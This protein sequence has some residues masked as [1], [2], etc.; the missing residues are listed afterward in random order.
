METH[1]YS[2]LAYGSIY[3]QA[4]YNATH[5][6]FLMVNAHYLQLDKVFQKAVSG[7]EYEDLKS[8]IEQLA[9]DMIYV[10]TKTLLE[11]ILPYVRVKCDW[12]LNA[13]EDLIAHIQKELTDYIS[14]ALKTAMT[15]F[16]TQFTLNFGQ[17]SSWRGL[18]CEY[19]SPPGNTA[20]ETYVKDF[21]DFVKTVKEDLMIKTKQA[22][23]FVNEMLRLLT[24]K[25]GSEFLKLYEEYMDIDTRTDTIIKETLRSLLEYSSQFDAYR[26]R[27]EK[28]ALSLT[29]LY[30]ISGFVV[31]HTFVHG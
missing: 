15:S 10:P 13:E 27:Y 4:K 30:D 23:L 22:V 14:N 24:P 18:S 2:Y 1:S 19:T 7:K 21:I 6:V 16:Y 31:N 9:S 17:C 20:V 3:S 12:C 28:N 8:A 25:C 29:N 5:D 11:G 26:E